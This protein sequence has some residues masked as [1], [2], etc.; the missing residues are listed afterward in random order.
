MFFENK[1]AFKTGE[2]FYHKLQ[3]VFNAIIALPLI[4]FALIYLDIQEGGEA[5]AFISAKLAFVLQWVLPAL[6]GGMA[7][8][9]HQHHKHQL[10]TVFEAANLRAKLGHYYKIQLIKYLYFGAGL[11]ISVAGYYLTRHNVFVV[12]FVFLLVLLS[13]GR[14]TLKK[15]I[16]DLRLNKEEAEVLQEKEE[17]E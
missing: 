4:P 12:A 16:A 11:L 13:I 7:Y 8:L 9:G 6:A 10:P 3:L 5:V 17:I 1:I 2:D 15:I 14:P